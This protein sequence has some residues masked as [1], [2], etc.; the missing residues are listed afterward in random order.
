[1]SHSRLVNLG[2][3]PS[4]LAS[5]P[6]PDVLKLSLY[7][8]GCPNKFKESVSDQSGIPVVKIV[9]RSKGTAFAVWNIRSEMT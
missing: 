7:R 5:R 8:D 1:M 4:K 3:T 9:T 6:I 2:A